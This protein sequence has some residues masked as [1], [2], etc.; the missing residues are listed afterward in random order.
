[1]DQSQ[2]AAR[3]RLD[4][5]L[6]GKGV[7]GRKTRLLACSDNWVEEDDDSGVSALD[8]DNKCM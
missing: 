6:P 8:P 2:G 1:M 7:S 5:A 4:R 3:E